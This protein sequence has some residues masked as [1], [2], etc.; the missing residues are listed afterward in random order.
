MEA[1]SQDLGP[2]TRMVERM[3]APSRGKVRIAVV[4]KYTELIDS[5]K[6]VQEALIHGGIANEVGV[7]IDWL[8]SEHDI[9][10]DMKVVDWEPEP[11]AGAGSLGLFGL[12]RIARWLGLSAA[13]DALEARTVKL[14][15]LLALWHPDLR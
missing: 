15:G 5:Y 12:G 4:G 14:E 9:S 7:E 11:A 10:K 6:S 3:K 2:W 1:P 8:S 13:V